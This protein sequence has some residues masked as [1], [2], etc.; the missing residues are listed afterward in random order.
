MYQV[1][2]PHYSRHTRPWHK[3][4]YAKPAVPFKKNRDGY[5]FTTTLEFEQFISFD[6]SSFTHEVFAVLFLDDNNV[7][8]GYERL[9][10]G[11]EKSAQIS[12]DLIH[13]KVRH[14]NAQRLVI[15]HNHPKGTPTLSYVDEALFARMRYF[16]RIYNVEIIDHILVAYH[17]ISSR[18]NS[19]AWLLL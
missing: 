14:Y 10:S 16:F 18:K 7:Y 2:E 12:F 4:K 13:E 5:R 3:E 17:G 1:S 6:L 15:G 11:D 8:L 9:F 19:D